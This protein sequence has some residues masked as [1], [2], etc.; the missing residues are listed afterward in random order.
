MCGRFFGIFVC[1]P[2]D[3]HTLIFCTRN[4]RSRYDWLCF[5]LC[6]SCFPL[7]LEPNSRYWSVGAFH[8][9][10]RCN[11]GAKRSGH[12][13]LHSDNDGFPPL[14]GW[15]KRIPLERCHRER[16]ERKKIALFHTWEAVLWICGLY[17]E[18]LCRYEKA[19]WRDGPSPQMRLG[20]L[21]VPA[22]YPYGAIAS[23]LWLFWQTGLISHTGSKFQYLS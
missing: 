15:Q 5:V 18:N 1:I 10:K 23:L 21:K 20:M 2:K 6:N 16:L 12:L 11:P 8:C 9:K 22:M 3:G 19:G 7:E 17:I 4:E 14:S 13:C